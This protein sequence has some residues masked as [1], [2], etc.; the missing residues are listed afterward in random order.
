MEKNVLPGDT[1]TMEGGSRRKLVEGEFHSVGFDH[2]FAIGSEKHGWQHVKEP[3]SAQDASRHCVRS[4]R[5]RTRDP[6]V[7]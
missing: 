4:A 7:G 6:L 2:D 5:R 1:T 3:E